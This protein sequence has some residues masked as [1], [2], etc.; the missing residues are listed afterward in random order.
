[1]HDI[2]KSVGN[3]TE[4]DLLQVEREILE[5]RERNAKKPRNG[6][7]DGS[8]EQSD[9]DRDYATYV[10]PREYKLNGGEGWRIV[11]RGG[12]SGD[13]SGTAVSGDVRLV[14]HDGR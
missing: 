14:R 4:E 12:A 5:T 9:A 2:L 8:D 1:M 10:P 13:R 3:L 6:S 7:D 11:K